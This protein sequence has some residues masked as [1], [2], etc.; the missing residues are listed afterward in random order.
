MTPRPRMAGTTK[1]RGRSQ[2]REKLSAL[3][4]R[5]TR[6]PGNRPAQMRRLDGPLIG[7]L[8]SAKIGL[9]AFFHYLNR[10]LYGVTES[11]RI[12]PQNLAESRAE[13]A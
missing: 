10:D 3:H 9:G 1:S 12:I 8:G 6:V 11:D 7:Y 5:I 4:P 13:V 2:P